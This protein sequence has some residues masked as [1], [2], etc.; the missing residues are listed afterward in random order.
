LADGTEVRLDTTSI[1][2]QLVV[3]SSLDLI[4]NIN[5]STGSYFDFYLNFGNNDLII[6]VNALLDTSSID[7]P[8]VLIKLYEPLPPQFVVNTPCWV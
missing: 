5:A 7:N 6:A 1:P 2:D 4:N 3:S 8:T